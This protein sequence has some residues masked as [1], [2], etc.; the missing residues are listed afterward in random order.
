MDNIKLIEYQDD[1]ERGQIIRCKGNYPYEGVVDFMVCES[2]ETDCGYSLFVLTG[3]KAGIRLV[4]LPEESIP[5]ENLGYA[6]DTA[7]LKQNWN[8]WIYPDCRLGDVWI[9]KPVIPELP[10]KAA[11]L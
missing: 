5:V 9:I 1:I 6:I 10:S 2:Y 7:W 8:N 11:K 3:S 4:V